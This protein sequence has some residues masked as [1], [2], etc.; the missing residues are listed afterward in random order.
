VRYE[1]L[2]T[3]TPSAVA[4]IGS[5][6]GVE[7]G[8]LDPGSEFRRRHT[9]AGNKVRFAPLEEIREDRAW[10]SGLGGADLVAVRRHAGAVAR[11]LGYDL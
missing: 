3:D 8:A 10:C 9:I 4:R 6:L 2:C 11:D 1:D 7:P 5:F